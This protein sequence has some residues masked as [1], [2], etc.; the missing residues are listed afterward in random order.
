MIT[1]SQSDVVRVGVRD[2]IRE[3]I[4][5]EPPADDET[6]LFHDLRIA[7]DDAWELMDGIV[8][9]FPIDATGFD[10]SQFFPSEGD[11]APYWLL[12][13]TG[14]HK[15]YKRL[16]VAHITEVAR[17]GKWFEPSGGI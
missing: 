7:G 12:R 11:T 13:L 14:L 2:A 1:S 5:C 3:I 17:R 15:R 4:A 8:K 6:A 16:T 10:F 9:R